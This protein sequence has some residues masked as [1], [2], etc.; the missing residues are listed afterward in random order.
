MDQEKK[1]HIYGEKEY[2]AYVSMLKK[3]SDG[4]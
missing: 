4:Y 3:M 2:N 1:W